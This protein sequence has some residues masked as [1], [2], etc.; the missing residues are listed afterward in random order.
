[1]SNLIGK[2]DKCG[3]DVYY[4]ASRSCGYRYCGKCKANTNKGDPVNTEQE[5][6]QW[7]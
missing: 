3:G 1:M 2:H 7:N 4:A 6:K 5:A